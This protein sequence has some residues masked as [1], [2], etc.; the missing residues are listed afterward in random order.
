M[1]RFRFGKGVADFS[2]SP[3]SQSPP[4]LDQ[5]NSSVSGVVIARSFAEG[6]VSLIEAGVQETDLQEADGTTPTST[7]RTDGDGF[8][9]PFF[10]P[11]TVS[12]LWITF[13]DGVTWRQIVSVEVVALAADF[14]SPL[15]V[16]GP[17]ET[18]PPPDTTP[19]TLVFREV[20]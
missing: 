11:D 10:G 13:N 12:N 3:P 20:F 15:V 8:L 18:E 17:A 16:I 6:Y 9:V 4:M 7:V 2:I 1:A 14:V 19:G 5:F